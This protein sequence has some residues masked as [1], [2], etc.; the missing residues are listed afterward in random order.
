MFELMQMLENGTI[1]MIE[2][3]LAQLKDT[4]AFIKLLGT[5]TDQWAADT[6]K[7]YEE[8]HEALLMLVEAHEG[9]NKLEGAMMP[10]K[11]GN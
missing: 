11:R 4:T 3:A 10:R 2:E 1:D 5:L 7:T 8:M 6:G 9:V